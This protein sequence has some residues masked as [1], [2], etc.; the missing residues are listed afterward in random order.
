MKHFLFVTE[1]I[2]DVGLL[3]SIIRHMGFTTEVKKLD[4]LDVYWKKL[5]PDRFP[6]DGK[7][8]SRVTPIP[9][10]FQ[11]EYVSIAIKVAEGESNI[12]IE[13]D[14]I[15]ATYNM[16]ELSDLN[17]IFVL[18]DADNMTANTKLE[19]LIK[20]VELDSESNISVTNDK[21]IF[22][23]IEIELLTYVFPN[24]NDSGNLETLLTELAKIKYNDLLEGSR[25]YI[26]TVYNNYIKQIGNHKDKSIIGCICNVLRPAASNNISIKNDSWICKDTI[27]SESLCHLYKKVY[28]FLN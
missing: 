25:N 17:G 18:C 14:N 16:S 4:K 28:D 2:D 13:I 23:D 9:S 27:E 6:F 5:I 15:L 26:D 12:F 7:K 19:K 10:F 20:A 8:L 22:K 21:I 24:N 11:G 3:S 1:G